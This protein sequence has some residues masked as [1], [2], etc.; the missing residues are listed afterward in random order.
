LAGRK[1]QP[2][3]KLVGGGWF[4]ASAYGCW[5]VS[6]TGPESST[7]SPDLLKQA[8]L[9]A[10]VKLLYLPPNV[11]VGHRAIFVADTLLSP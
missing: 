7:G 11:D 6:G 5:S 4:S 9:A 10:R 1:K 3:A 8:A 2:P